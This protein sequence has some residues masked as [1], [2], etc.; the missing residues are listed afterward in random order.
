MSVKWWIFQIMIAVSIGV[1]SMA[2]QLSKECLFLV[3]IAMV[4]NQ[5]FNGTE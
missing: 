3:I 1:S 4:L 2:G 5:Q